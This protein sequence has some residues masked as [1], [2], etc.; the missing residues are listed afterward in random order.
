MYL[1]VG[2]AAAK[3]AIPQPGRLQVQVPIMSLNLLNLPNVINVWNSL[4]FKS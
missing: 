3:R 1:Y 4:Q 2:R